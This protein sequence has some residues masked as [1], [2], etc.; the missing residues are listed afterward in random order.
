MEREYTQHQMEQSMMVNGKMG[1]IMAWE[2]FS[3]Q[4]A[5]YIEESGRIVGKMGKASFR[6]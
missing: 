5:V 4:M 6:E 2:H 1:S 3:G